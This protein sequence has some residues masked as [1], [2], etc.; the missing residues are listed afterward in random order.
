MSD[1]SEP[2]F[3]GPVQID[4]MPADPAALLD[5]YRSLLHLLL[6]HGWPD[7]NDQRAFLAEVAMRDFAGWVG[8]ESTGMLLEELVNALSVFDARVH[9]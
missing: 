7:D 6:A 4:V 5:G 9:P 1:G 3:S 8:N 2:A